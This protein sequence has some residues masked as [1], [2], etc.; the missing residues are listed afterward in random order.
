ME[1]SKNICRYTDIYIYLNEQNNLL[2]NESEI[3]NI[4]LNFKH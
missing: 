2:S 1:S 3:L 4:F